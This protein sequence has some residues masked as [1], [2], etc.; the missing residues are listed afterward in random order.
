ML[1]DKLG[2][3]TGKV[4]V[5]RVLPSRGGGPILEIS[6]EQTGA[7]LG[8]QTGGYAT[9]EAEI[10]PDGKVAGAGRGLL[11]GAGGEMATWTATGLGVFK[12]GGDIRFTGSINY[13]TDSPTWSQLNNSAGVFEWEEKADG[14]SQAT[15]WEWK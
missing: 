11:M 2:D 13:L 7:L 15:F 4:T 9:Y 6:L 8:V 10:R 5:R 1:G 3:L 12:E 14:S